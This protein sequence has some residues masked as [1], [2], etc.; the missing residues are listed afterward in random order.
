MRVTQ[1]GTKLWC[2]HC[3]VVRV[4]GAKNPGTMGRPAGQ[5]WYRNGHYDIRW[6]RRGRICQNCWQQFF[7]A[8]LHEEMIEELVEL[9]DALKNIKEKADACL[10]QAATA[11]NSIDDL[12]AS[13][14]TLRALWTYKSS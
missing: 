3:Q 11:S 7:T 2:P 9:R 5:R 1:G 12:K 8:E 4:C 13:L 10:K 14:S 6:F